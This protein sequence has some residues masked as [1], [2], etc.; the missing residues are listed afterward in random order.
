MFMVVLFGYIARSNQ[1]TASF[2][3]DNSVSLGRLIGFKDV[4]GGRLYIAKG[5]TIGRCAC[6]SDV[7]KGH[8]SDLSHGICI[9]LMMKMSR[10][11]SRSKP[12]V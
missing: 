10:T 8:S 1:S 2:F 11:R 4:N 3:Q 7:S 9:P 6:A 12:R 5:E